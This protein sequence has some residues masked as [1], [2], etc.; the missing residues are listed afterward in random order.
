MTEARGAGVE[1]IEKK[2]VKC[3]STTTP[4]MRSFVPRGRPKGNLN[5]TGG[6][7]PILMTPKKRQYSAVKNKDR[8]E[9]P[10]LSCISAAECPLQT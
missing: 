7:M 6:L 10:R 1:D 9:R 5:L 4:S 2:K 8:P 3:E